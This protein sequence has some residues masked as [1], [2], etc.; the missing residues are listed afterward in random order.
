MSAIISLTVIIIASAVIYFTGSWFARASS[1]IG[2]YLSLPRS[3]KGATFDAIS[4]SLPELLIA[5]FSVLAFKKFEVGIGT[6]AG[7]ALFNLLVIPG[8]CVLV[9]P[10]LFTVAKDVIARDGMFYNISVFALLAA[11]LYSRTWGLAIPILFL[12]VYI[13]Y[14][15]AIFKRTNKHKKEITQEQKTETRKKIKLSK[16]LTIGLVTLAVIAAASYFLT[17]HAIEF[18]AAIGVP[19]IIVAF[20]IIA[21]ATSLP[22]TVIS[23]INARKGNIDDATSNVF[24][25]NIF[26]ILVG[27]SLPL[28]I[29]YYFTGPVNIAFRHLEI[30]V[31]LMGST[32]LVLYFL[33]EEHTLRKKEAWIL[34]LMYF[35]FIAYVVFLGLNGA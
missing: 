20:T 21:A 28:L 35:A 12:T 8:I 26:D 25:S 23:V 22:D 3:V 6:I 4:S 24:G 33:A 7:S 14:V 10:K 5:I 18:A 11:L 30:V 2:D 19:A 17:E 27:L 15:I 31:A 16:E 29:A 13:W 1:N 32:I 9:A 34:L